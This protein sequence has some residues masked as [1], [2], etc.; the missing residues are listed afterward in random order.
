MSFV[1]FQ[2]NSHVHQ[3]HFFLA[4]LYLLA[5][6]LAFFAVN[7]YLF[8]KTLISS[9]LNFYLLEKLLSFF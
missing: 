1:P 8:G 2:K 9:W 4:K 3:G 7:F 6:L 5:N